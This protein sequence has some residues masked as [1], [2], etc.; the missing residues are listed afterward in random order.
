MCLC[1]LSAEAVLRQEKQIQVPSGVKELAPERSGLR[2]GCGTVDMHS[3]SKT[4]GVSPLYPIVAN[5]Y[6]DP[7]LPPNPVFLV[8]LE[9]YAFCMKFTGNILLVQFL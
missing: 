2:G 7:G 5:S 9:I 1:S 8:K 6:K 4:A 3:T